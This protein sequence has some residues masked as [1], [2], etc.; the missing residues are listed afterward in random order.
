MIK[1]V[2]KEL[3]ADWKVLVFSLA[4][5]FILIFGLAKFQNDYSY[6]VTSGMDAF[7]CTSQFM[8]VSVFV[9]SIF[10]SISINKNNFKPDRVV[11]SKKNTSV[12][13]YTII[14]TVILALI[15]SV[16]IFAVT[17]FISK[18]FFEDFFNWNTKESAFYLFTGMLMEDINY[19]L[20]LT[21]YF[22]QCFFGICTAAIAPLISFWYFKSY[23]S[24]AIIATILILAGHVSSAA[25]LYEQ[26]ISYFTLVEGIDIRYHFIFP[27]LALLI[28]II[29]GSMKTKRDF[30]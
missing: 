13:N 8:P 29:A 17:F 14:K 11:L 7:A 26:N 16:F 15:M 9:V 12:W 4:I 6:A 30:I 5:M 3:L 10:L 2:L 19:V 22:C 25:F 27:P 24:G 20:V 21:A 28:L 23:V 1:R 18:V